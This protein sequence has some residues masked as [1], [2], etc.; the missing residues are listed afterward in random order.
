MR[1]VNSCS[2]LQF[3]WDGEGGSRIGN[4]RL[5][6]GGAVSIAWVSRNRFWLKLNGT[7]ITSAISKRT[8]SSHHTMCGR[9]SAIRWPNW[10]SHKVSDINCLGP[11]ETEMVRASPSDTRCHILAIDCYF[12]FW[13]GAPQTE[14]V[15]PARPTIWSHD[16]IMPCD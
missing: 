1:Q 8:I 5:D 4:C 15:R 2:L 10:P 3:E 14:L 13:P 11:E 6:R 9:V 7:V 16:A 12:C